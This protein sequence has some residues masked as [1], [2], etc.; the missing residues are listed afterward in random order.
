MWL[1][2]RKHQLLIATSIWL[3]VFYF[4]P[5]FSASLNTSKGLFLFAV[6][7]SII[8]I[9]GSVIGRKFSIWL[10]I[11]NLLS[12]PISV[13]IA[14]AITGGTLVV[15]MSDL[16]FGKV[17]L[18]NIN[19]EVPIKWHFIM[20]VIYVSFLIGILYILRLIF[21]GAKKLKSYRNKKRSTS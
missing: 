3:G 7:F 17:N 20:S 14:Y 5:D 11:N 21:L 2:L 12:L 8:F 18:F 9:C 16:M 4:L 10:G 15:S 13:I 6:T 19:D 1:H